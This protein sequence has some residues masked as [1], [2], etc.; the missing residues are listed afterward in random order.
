VLG[1]AALLGRTFDWDLL[2]GMADADGRTVVDALRAAVVDQ[3]IEADGD[4]FRFRHALTRE[5]VLTD[6]LPP[7]Q[8]ELAARAWPAIERAHPGLPGTTCLLAA[9]LAAA[10]GDT[11]AAAERLVESARRALA[12]GAMATAEAT[13]RRAR[14]LADG[15]SD[16]ALDADEVLVDVLAAAGKP[17]DALVLGRD[18]ADRFALAEA[19]PPRRADLLLVLA[20]AAIAAGDLAVAERAVTDARSVAGTRAGLTLLARLDT[21]ATE[22]ALDRADLDTAERLGWR[23]VEEGRATDQPAVVCEALLLLGRLARPEGSAKAVERFQQAAD[24]AAAAGLARW[25]LRAQQE[26]AL[27]SW[28]T[29]GRAAIRETRDL[30]ARFGAHLTVAVMDLSLADLALSDFDHSG[31]LDSATACVEASRRY[32]LATEPVA[33]LW[34]AGA[35]ALGGDDDAMHAAIDAALARDRDDPRILGDLNGRVL[36]T[37]AFVRDELDRL[38]ELLDEMMDHVRRAP[39]TTSVYP[40]RVYWALLHTVDDDDLGVAARSEYHDDA[41]RIGH[42]MFP[43]F[44]EIVEAVA[45]GRVGEADAA[46]PRMDAAY[47]PLTTSP[48]SQGMAHASSLIVARAAI[49]DGW[50]DPVRWLRASEAWFAERGLD[51]LVRRSRVLLREAGAPAPRRGR[52][53]SEVPTSL[54]ALG[55]TSREMDVLKLV[56]A[57][58][59]TKQ[60]AAELYIAPKTVERHLT[61]LFGRTGVSNR[62]ELAEVGVAHLAN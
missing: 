56:V 25:Q 11:A 19:S 26:L 34:L 49:R 59:T 39:R 22:V 45:L 2:P 52:G 23:A 20:R 4:R 5:A 33:E 42:A 46:T 32:G 3:L 58:R 16:R 38:P 21:V 8:R 18:L 7:E 54:R 1:A 50:G 41:A 13:A 36:T 62:H 30:A 17:A 48:L 53:D 14:H 31:C 51:R 27:E 40:G 12:S 61:S 37:R 29:R 44:G 55:V 10:A 43:Q 9:D 57:G 28:P 6:L 47:E 35:H 60:I 15:D 24:T